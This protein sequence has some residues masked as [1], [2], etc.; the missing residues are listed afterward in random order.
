MRG[1]WNRGFAMIKR[2]ELSRGLPGPITDCSPFPYRRGRFAPHVASV[3]N[4][5][6]RRPP[7]C[8]PPRSEVYACYEPARRV[9]L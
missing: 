8:T 7:S 4:D 2:R 9:D 5:P 6:E 3:A 1:R